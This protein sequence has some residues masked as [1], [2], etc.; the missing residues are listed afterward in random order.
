MLEDYFGMLDWLC[1]HCDNVN[2]VNADG[3]N[4]LHLVAQ[5][6][7]TNKKIKNDICG[8]LIIYDCDPF[9]KNNCGKTPLDIAQEA[10]ENFDREK[11]TL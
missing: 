4:L 2:M 9:L 3:N 7:K 11:W 8:I 5:S 10:Y 6:Y 1:E